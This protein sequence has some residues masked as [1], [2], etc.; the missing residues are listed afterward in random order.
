MSQT[1]EYTVFCG[2]ASGAIT[3]ETIK[4]TIQPN[5]ALVEIAHAGLC[6]SD[7]VSRNKPVPLGHH[8]TG[9]VRDIGDHVE[10]VLPGD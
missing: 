1:V 9:I 7:K 8:G 5:E 6:G 10:H 3:P 2:L 4:R